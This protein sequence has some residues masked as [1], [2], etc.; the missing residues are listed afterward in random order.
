VCGGCG[1]GPGRKPWNSHLFFRRNR[2]VIFR[3]FLGRLTGCLGSE[4]SE[5]DIYAL[6]GLCVS[7]PPLPPLHKGGKLRLCAHQ[8]CAIANGCYR[9]TKAAFSSAQGQGGELGLAS[10][11]SSL[12]GSHAQAPHPDD[13]GLMKKWNRVG[14]GTG[15]DRAFFVASSTADRA[16]PH[17]PFGHPLPVGAREIRP[18]LEARSGLGSRVVPL[19]RPSG[20]VSPCH[21][22]STAP[23]V[24]REFVL[25]G[26][27]KSA[28]GIDPGRVSGSVSGH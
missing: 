6:A 26:L 27:N 23:G 18:S 21:P 1:G 2:T 11:T 24:V 5:G 8:K 13:P 25:K 19:T 14:V 20:I 9:P 28:R 12:L 17:P 7:T 22:P 4:A 15:R 10:D 16:P 3:G